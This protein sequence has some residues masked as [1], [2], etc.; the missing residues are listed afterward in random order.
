[1]AHKLHNGSVLYSIESYDICV[2]KSSDRI[3][4]LKIG[5][6]F[7][8]QNF[9]RNGKNAWLLRQLIQV[10]AQWRSYWLWLHHQLMSC[11][12]RRNGVWFVAIH[13][14]CQ[15]TSVLHL[16]VK[17][18]PVTALSMH[19][20]YTECKLLEDTSLHDKQY[21]HDGTL[22]SIFILSSIRRRMIWETTL[23]CSRAYFEIP[24]RYLGR[25]LPAH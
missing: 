6:D 4:L 1:M 12:D 24:R 25:I 15:T 11:K 5:Q 16:A 17:F 2:C 14:G 9:S 3:P 23:M 10:A 20:A 13:W 19:N 18:M 8:L 7:M 21:T 22:V